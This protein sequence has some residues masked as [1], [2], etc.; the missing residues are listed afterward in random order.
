ME[1]GD[2]LAVNVPNA[3]SIVIMGA[4]GGL[5]LT[6]IRRF[7]LGKMNVSNAP[8]AGGTAF[9]SSIPGGA[10]APAGAWT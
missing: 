1:S 5:I 4:V 2:I 3:V 6:G 8:A 7:V 9:M 10:S